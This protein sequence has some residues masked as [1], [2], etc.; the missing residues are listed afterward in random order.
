ML[1][2]STGFITNIPEME[3]QLTVLLNE[4]RVLDRRIREL[5]SK[6]ALANYHP[7]MFT[8]ILKKICKDHG[9]RHF[10]HILR[11]IEV[12]VTEPPC[13]IPCRSFVVRHA[14]VPG[15]EVYCSALWY[16]WGGQSV[17]WID[18]E[19]NDHDVASMF[20]T[21]K[22]G[23][24]F[25]SEIGLSRKWRGTFIL[26]EDD[27]QSDPIVYE[28][29]DLSVELASIPKVLWP[30][31]ILRTGDVPLHVH[32]GLLRDIQAT[33]VVEEEETEDSDSDSGTSSCSCSCHPVE[34]GA[35]KCSCCTEAMGEDEVE[36]DAEAE[37]VE[38]VL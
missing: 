34:E 17:C 14:G 2:G 10:N 8:T 32:G 21:D 28:L 11:T 31:A 25:A 5:Q 20:F 13:Y 4:K 19:P 24:Y 38:E 33:A 26:T 23:G 18:A 36:S 35:S 16:K 15:G 1:V 27:M 3:A 30:I 6:I 9:L 37:D 29:G 7:S 22:E 12:N